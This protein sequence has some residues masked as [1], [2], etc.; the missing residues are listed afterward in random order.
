MAS[1]VV[2]GLVAVIG[3]ILAFG[4]YSIPVLLSFHFFFLNQFQ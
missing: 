2:L 1:D 4:C 3:A